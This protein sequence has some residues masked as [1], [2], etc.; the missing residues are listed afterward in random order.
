MDFLL[1]LFEFVATCLWI[2][3]WAFI[4][5]V[6]CFVL[7]SILKAIRLYL[8]DKREAELIACW[9]ERNKL[10]AEAVLDLDSPDPLQRALAEQFI[11]SL[12]P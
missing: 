6:G 11:D 2:L 12:L 3:F 5:G 4:A 7:Y 8:E 10:I 9:Q 1:N